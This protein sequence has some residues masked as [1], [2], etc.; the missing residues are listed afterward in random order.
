MTD[1]LIVTGMMSGTSLDGMDLVCCSFSKREKWTWEVLGSVTY[2]YPREWKDRLTGAA[3]LGAE[4]FILLHQEYGRYI[5]EQVIRFHS[6]IGLQSDLVASHGHT[7]FHQPG[8]RMTFQLGEGAAIAA[9]CSINTVSDFRTFDVALGGQ[10]APLV[11]I[12][13]ELLFSSYR[14]CLNLGGFANISTWKNDRVA[15]D[16]CPVNIVLNSL[17]QRVGMEYDAEGSLGRS[18]NMYPE[19][20]EKL[21]NLEFYKTTGPKSLGREWV[22]T[23]FMQVLDAH[24]LSLND[25][26]ASVYEHIGRQIGRSVEK[27]KEGEMLI[28]GGGAFNTYLLER[29]SAYTPIKLVVPDENIVKFKEAIIFAFLGLL[30]FRHEIN[31]LQSVTGATRNSSSGVVHHA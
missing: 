9:T 17:S 3:R 27:E 7:I 4:E 22:E 10:G 23:T 15:F 29:I 8:K 19:L 18:G 25:L 21:D 13:D 31:C 1:S 14:Y 24:V 26:M 20:V 11:P 5:G 30:R 6:S 28:T 16:I 2:D 12:G